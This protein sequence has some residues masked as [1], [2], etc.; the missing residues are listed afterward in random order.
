MKQYTAVICLALGLS[1]TIGCCNKGSNRL[2]VVLEGPWIVYQDT[3]FDS[4]GAKIPVL[5][6][7]AP[8]S[9]TSQ[10]MVSG[11]YFHH[12]SPQLSTGDGFYIKQDY[13][14]RARIFC[15]FFDDKCAPGTVKIPAT[16]MYPESQALHLTPKGGQKT[17]DWV[18][19]VRGSGVLA[20][21]LIL[22]MPDSISNDG[23]WV[24]R[25]NS[26][27]DEKHSIGLQLHYNNGPK[28]LM[29]RACDESAQ[30]GVATCNNPIADRGQAEPSKL[31]N[32]GTLRLQMR[33]PDN[34]DACDWHVRYAWDQTWKLLG[35]D[36]PS[37]YANIEPAAS[38]DSDGK[39]TYISCDKNSPIKGNP[40]IKYP[41]DQMPD[42]SGHMEGALSTSAQFSSEMLYTDFLNQFNTDIKAILDSIEEKH[43]NDP[44]LKY[45]VTLKSEVGSLNPNFP[46]ISQ[47]V[48]IGKL[49]DSSQGLIDRLR[50]EHPTDKVLM[51]ELKEFEDRA[52]FVKEDADTK[53]GGDCRA[54]IV[55]VN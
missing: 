52:K 11:D 4:R 34:T 33:A 22:P 37:D 55:A 54:A 25:F 28:N 17:W 30:P 21:A 27:D 12:H 23:V 18:K 10:A 14:K 9:A 42:S 29:L 43:K 6:A 5:V 51:D 36:F 48:L 39:A 1:C 7:I 40:S 31:E 13:L 38:I 24:M 15:L 20:A 3:Q 45:F 8:I 53:N 44:D 41:K 47:L 49:L 16:D 35:T 19:A 46:R 26:K 50:K 2:D 32:T